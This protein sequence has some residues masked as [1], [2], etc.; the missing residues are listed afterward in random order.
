MIQKH[1]CFQVSGCCV[2][3]CTLGNDGLFFFVALMLVWLT[4]AYPALPP[5]SEGL[6]VVVL[7]VCRGLCGW[8]V[9]EQTRSPGAAF[10]TCWWTCTSCSPGLFF[11][12]GILISCCSVSNVSLWQPFSVLHSLFALFFFFFFP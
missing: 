12:P 3:S 1:K 2:Q 9:P 4:F 11:D 8:N 6:G 10:E 5:F 7:S